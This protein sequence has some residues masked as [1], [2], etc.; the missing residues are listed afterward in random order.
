[1][2]YK[3]ISATSG[4]RSGE[5]FVCFISKTKIKDF[6]STCL[7]TVTEEFVRDGS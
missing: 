4:L 2:S 7:Q 3:I 1:M 6:T 5:K